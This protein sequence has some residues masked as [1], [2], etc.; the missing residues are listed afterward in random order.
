MEPKSALSERSVI[1]GAIEEIIVRLNGAPRTPELRALLI[2]ALRLRSVASTWWA[3]PPPPAASKEMLVKIGELA[4]LVPAPPQ[5]SRRPASRSPAPTLAY[6]STPAPGSF[7][8]PSDAPRRQSD[9]VPR[10]EPGVSIPL[11]P[12]VAFVRPEAMVWQS[13]RFLPG[14]SVKVLSRDPMERRYTALLHME[15]RTELPPHR[16]AASEEI[17]VL[18]GVLNIGLV[19]IHAGEM[20][21]A[22]Q[23]SVHDAAHTEAG[24]TLLISGAEHDR[25]RGEL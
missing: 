15:P 9:P 24:C 8:P 25:L 5:S 13:L 18:E 21:R 11:G 2:E 22:E 12:G 17:F 20:S 1:H 3:V 4:S 23:G 7:R 6:G 16:H 19:E 14:V 10:S